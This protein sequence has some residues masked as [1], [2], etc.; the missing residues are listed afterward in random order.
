MRTTPRRLVFFLMLF[1]LAFA[2][3]L[4][5]Q[6][7]RSA[8][9]P[10]P[11]MDGFGGSVAVS[12]DEVFVTE[13]RNKYNP[14]KVYVYRENDDGEWTESAKLTSDAAAENDQFG[15]AMAAD[16]NTLLVSG[17]SGENEAASVHAFRRDGDEWQH[18]GRFSASDAGS[19]SGFGSAIAVEGDWAVIGAPAASKKTGAA[20]VFEREGE[21]DWQQVG[22]LEGSSAESGALFGATL[23]LADGQVL[24]GA[25]GRT[26][27]GQSNTSSRGKVFVFSRDD[28]SEQT[29]LSGS[30]AKQGDA[31]G[32][33][34]VQR[35][36]H[37]IVGAP[38]HGQNVGA[39]F[40][41][42]RDDTSTGWNEQVRLLPFD[43]G[44]QHFFGAALSFTGGAAWLGSPGANQF[45]G[46]AYRY[47][48]SDR[49]G[50]WSGATQL[51]P[52]K[53]QSRDLFGATIS[54]SED[55]AAVGK[56]GGAGS[57][58]IFEKTRPGNWTEQKTL[59]GDIGGL[60]AVTGNMS[61]CEDGKSTRYDCSNVDMISFLPI[62]DIGGDR[63]INLNDVWGWTDPE[64]GT[65]YA[66]VGRTDGTSFVDISDPQ[67]PVY[68]GQLPK[69]DG[70]KTT[71]WRDIK[72]YDDHAFIV[73]DAAPKHGLQIF[74]L[75]Q[76]RDVDV[77]EMPVT[78][79]E[80]ARYDEVNSVH[81][82]VINKDTGFAY[83]VGSGGGGKTCGGGLHMINIQDPMN[84]TFAG[85]YAKEG[86]GR[87]GTG[88][89]HD[90]QC[91]VYEGPDEEHQGQ[92]ICLNS[93]ETAFNIADVTDKD[94]PVSLATAEY[95][96]SAYTHQG[97][98]SE[99][100]RYFYINDEIDE[101]S[102]KV[103]KTRTLIWNIT[104]LDD[105]QLVKQ[106]TY[107]T[108]SSD[109]NLYVKGDRMYMSN[110]KSGLR[111]HDIS[112]PA[113]PK[114]IGYFDTSPIGDNSP[115]YQGT[116][117]NY[118]FFESGV[119]PVSSIGEGL[120]LLKRKQTSL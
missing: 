73:S 3:A 77:G 20:Y 35:G 83:A 88:Y 120:F 1:A 38:R 39:A 65:E 75:T 99:D 66:L 94:D 51:T 79:E 29:V 72:T 118:P 98:I 96:N 41:F 110:Y 68:V 106:Y 36:D 12:G 46:T 102:G 56:M 108:K 93:N 114:P 15:Q 101:I 34:I 27:R 21:G 116:W 70:A 117:S 43:G 90:A 89:T 8:T 100:H 11:Q 52:Q 84:P 76:L 78:F 45:E 42:R 85:C 22:M 103:E 33:S 105:P 18:S 95:P 63:G 112:D 6:S 71:S 82:I 5:A 113:N 97:W 2:P 40:V 19:K 13:A 28:W 25:P 81:N 23:A 30:S 86:T 55:V 91:L 80:T 9:S 109:H 57:V 87:S 48:L 16:G 31:F 32:T 54:A 115:G 17:A 53:I 50:R 37:L 59:R 10:L 24:V 61:P 44:S 26:L 74:D 107:G 64:T 104:D 14:G 67:N 7:Y 60:D 58:V 49:E 4:S 62:R 119:I 47:E 92:E 69:T 111:V